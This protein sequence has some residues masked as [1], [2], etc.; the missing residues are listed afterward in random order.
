MAAF[1]TFD[2]QEHAVL[3]RLPQVLDRRSH[4]EQLEHRGNIV[5]GIPDDGCRCAWFFLR[6]KWEGRVCDA[7]LQGTVDGECRW[8]YPFAFA[9][10]PSVR[11]GR[12]DDA[13]TID[14]EWES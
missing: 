2:M 4:R 10:S 13:V 11:S 8:R 7:V 9:L 12:A 6:E 1:A 5:K 3:G 14:W